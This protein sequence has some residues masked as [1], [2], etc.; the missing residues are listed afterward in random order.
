MRTFARISVAI[1]LACVF[2]PRVCFALQGALYS[3]GSAPIPHPI[4]NPALMRTPA[5]WR[6]PFGSWG[7]SVAESYMRDVR[8]FDDIRQI[9]NRSGNGID[10]TAVKRTEAGKIIDVKFVEVKTTSGR[11]IRLHSTKYGEQ[12][13]REWVIKHLWD[14]RNSDDP[15]IRAFGKEV[16]SFRRE[17]PQILMENYCELH[18]ID[19]KNLRF[20]ILDPATKGVKTDMSLTRV[21]K[22]VERRSKSPIMVSAAKLNFASQK[23]IRETSMQTWLGKGKVQTAIRFQSERRLPSKAFLSK[24]SYAFNRVR[25]RNAGRVALVVAIAVDAKEVYNLYESFRA[26]R[27]NQ[28]EF[29][30]G[31]CRTSCGIAGA[32]AGGWAGAA[33]GAWIGTF[34]GPIA[35]VTVPVGTFVGGAIG[36]AIGYYSGS[37]A[38][39][40]AVAFYYQ[41]LD[42]RIKTEVQNW[43]VMESYP[44]VWAQFK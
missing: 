1:A 12:L 27:I 3:M 6:T 16:R 40:A 11:G 8:G 24:T 5:G 38:G 31:L 2:C 10:L 4:N 35:F 20:K 29:T 37:K 25:L 23:T 17:N 44:A 7:E 41:K 39:S 32:W 33:T 14:M 18:H 13:S 34:G 36:S 19:A 21:F 22:G 42:V 28:R 9:R 30:E 15:Q 26:G 43:F